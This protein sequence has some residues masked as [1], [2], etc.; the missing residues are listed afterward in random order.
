MP[1]PTGTQ[2]AVGDDGSFL[3]LNPDES[4]TKNV[5][6]EEAVPWLIQD[7]L[8][9]TPT[10]VLGLGQSLSSAKWKAPTISVE[11]M[12][13]TEAVAYLKIVGPPGSGDPAKLQ[14][15]HR[16]L[17][18]NPTVINVGTKVF[19]R[20]E[21]AKIWG[22][23]AVEAAEKNSL[24]NA[25]N[26]TPSNVIQNSATQGVG[27]LPAGNTLPTDGGANALPPNAKG[28][29]ASEDTHGQGTA[30]SPQQDQKTGGDPL[31]LA[32]G[33]LFLQ[34]TDFAGRGRGIHFAFTR[35]YLHQT[36]YRGPLGY[37][38]DHCYNLWLREAQELQPDGSVA[39]VVYRSNGELRE[40]RFLHVHGGGA[41]DPL[42]AIADAVFH[43]PPGYFDELSKVAG[44]YRLRMVNGTVITYNAELRVDS[45]ADLSGNRLSFTY[46]N[47]LLTR[48]TDAVGKIFDF[49]NDVCGRV[50]QVID[51]TG[52]RRV[53]YAYDDI[54]NLL[55]V[56]IF[57]D[58]QTAT[59]T[60]YVY[61]GVDAA[62]G[63]EHNLVEVIGADGFAS[64]FVQYGTQPDPWTYN[65]VI[66]QRSQDGAYLYDYGPAEFDIDP[67]LDDGINLP[68]RVTTVT[69]PNG[70]VIEHAFNKQG[71]VVRRR[72]DADLFVA[73]GGA[74]VALYNYNKEG[75]LVREQ[76]PDGATVSYLYAGDVYEELNGEGSALE[77]D[78]GERLG[79]GNL[80]RRAETAR[81]GSGETRQIVTRW[82]YRPG[83]SRVETQRGPYY[84]DPLGNEIP[85]QTTP[86]I[87]YA[88]D[89]KARLLQ[90]HYGAVQTANGT[91]QNLP[92][93]EFSYDAHGS[94]SELR[95]GTLVTRYRYFSDL[96]R[97]GFI[98]QRIEDAGGIARTT[99]FDIDDLG[100][101]VG[102]RDAYGAEARWKY[103]G[104]D[105]VT[106]AT[107]PSIGGTSPV[108]QVKYDRARRI[109]QL[110]EIVVLPDGSLHPDGPLIT[111]YRYD[112]NG[113]QI[114]QSMGPASNPNARRYQTIYTPWGQPRRKIDAAG[115]VT[116]FQYN[117]RNLLRREREAAGTGAQRDRH[118]H[119]NRSGEVTRVFD[120]LGHL[121][122]FERDGFGRVSAVIDRDGNRSESDYDAQGRATR[123]R[124]VG[125]NLG[126]TPSKLW[127]EAKLQFDAVGRLIRRTDVL[128]Q[129]EDP[130]VVPR[131]LVTMYFY[132]GFSR[133]SELHDPGGMVLRFSY[134]GLGRVT[135]T[136]DGDGNALRTEYDD[137]TRT[138]SVVSE[139]RAFGAA[140]ARSQFFRMS[141][142]FDELGLPAEETDSLGNTVQ[143]A[144]DSRGRRTAVTLPDARV[145]S[146]RYDIFG[147]LLEQTIG[148]GATVLTT[149]HE[150][151]AAGRRIA[152]VSPR[153]DRTELTYDARG[154]ITA[155]AT[156]LGIRRY[157]YDA[158]SRLIVEELA[159]GLR[160]YRT[161]SHEG[162]Q[163]TTAVDQSGYSPP[164]TLPTYAPVA[165][166]PMEYA[167]SPAGRLLRMEE[168]GSS[169]RF[170]YDSLH[171]VVR[172]F[173][174][175]TEFGY[176]WDDSG[177][178]SRLTFGDGRQVVYA[179][180]PGGYLT[181]IE[182]AQKGTGYPGDASLPAART[183]ATIKRVGPRVDHL[184]L[185]GLFEVDFDYDAGRRLVGMDYTFDGTILQQL[186]ILQG[187][188]GQRVLD[189]CSERLRTFSYDSAGRLEQVTDRP[190]VAVNVQALA[191]A[192]SA[193]GLSSGTTQMG[194]DTLAAAAQSLAGSAQRVFDYTFDASG[195]RETAKT[196][197][198]SGSVITNYVPM[199]GD[200]YANIDGTTLIYDADGNLLGDD[201]RAFRYDALG[202]LR[203]VAEG[204]ATTMLAYDP[205]GRLSTL[206][207]NGTQSHF[208]WAG[209]ALAEIAE[210]AG[211][212]A[213][214]Q[215]VPGDH[216]SSPVH[217]AANNTEYA[218]LLDDLNSVI[219]WVEAGGTQVGARTF[220]PF[221]RL[222]TQAGASPAPIA[223]A[224]Y[225]GGPAEVSWSFARAYDAR[226]GR[227][228]QCDPLGFVDGPNL[229]AFARNAPG[230][231]VDL[232]GYKS[233]DLDAGTVVWEA[234][235]TVATG[236]AVVAGGAA[237]VGAGIAS[238]PFVATVGVLVMV[239]VGMNSFFNRSEEAFK[240]GQ[241][242][243]AGAAGLAAL[244]DTIGITNIVEGATGKDAV[245]DRTLGSQ[246]RS[247]R[248][249]TGI[250]SVGT[251]M[252]GPKAGNFGKGIGASLN[253]G[254][255]AMGAVEGSAFRIAIQEGKPVVQLPEL[256]V[257]MTA[258]PPRQWANLDYTLPAPP[259]GEAIPDLPAPF[260]GGPTSA[261]TPGGPVI[262]SG[263]HGPYPNAAVDV[264]NYSQNNGLPLRPHG[265]FDKMPNLG[266]EGAYASTHAELKALFVDPNAN[267]AIVNRN[268]CPGCQMSLRWLAAHRG[269]PITVLGPSGFYHFLPDGTV[270]AP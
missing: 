201:S 74:L 268:P 216:P 158:E 26:P 237:L 214:T 101:M 97:S 178:R 243:P 217:V 92:A 1:P 173:T 9:G 215:L 43:G 36:T 56:D 169:V 155:A 240:A 263:L 116:E 109:Q 4:I 179:Y 266:A 241:T 261:A 3:R 52:G 44:V 154:R 191:P 141:T 166:G 16:V 20:D 25:D 229:Y 202:R 131:E 54:G 85:G 235:K 197:G 58:A 247:Q 123:R 107:A 70:H 150:Y 248:L 163:L 112:Q 126:P 262:D 225:L 91:V 37:S 38:W 148:D 133:L 46:Q 244:G 125:P 78:S 175:A 267:F 39:N 223:F 90:I 62:A 193:S 8:R 200:R 61:L 183:L 265:F 245:T 124:L 27:P 222:L 143:Q 82:T 259:P 221:G 83:G 129:P 145:M 86:S 185:P 11:G 59:S 172:E 108:T 186:R 47:G 45:I 60:D 65:R 224:G 111:R 257:D 50:A 69:Y 140:P 195:N 204:G 98:A 205:I 35:T 22:A 180:T 203:E 96:L 137:A 246:E 40:D 230:T 194:V 254:A 181:K 264:W 100:R 48:V 34:V 28:G 32:T 12:A 102:M 72:E 177:R 117:G 73:G 161:Y 227:F 18:D 250:G 176:D 71:N 188:G 115:G 260:K 87:T 190:P 88:Y 24:E 218:P 212:P 171:R 7:Y 2:Y 42:G 104:F 249:G 198:L 128:F 41:V 89:G 149:L 76:R 199:A 79:F 144:Y 207:D 6:A 232:F 228:L 31:I 118:F 220:D 152:L 252:L 80:L 211:G 29:S 159:S 105:L 146:H 138:V 164:A 134:D 234:T 147:Q 258:K 233:N 167:Y 19:G 157:R 256:N 99:S 127:A 165:I 63:L 121:T 94:L 210:T 156:P 93:A 162:L 219:G 10:L 68:L 75:L 15:L 21:A 151:D 114:E 142:K 184:E 120:G 160:I 106:E 168:A 174:S 14:K 255:G 49:V 103:N 239:G 135:E 189:V 213:V 51:R 196:T 236:A 136:I 153:G 57:A 192:S 77:A 23:Q 253:P 64:L 209:V 226:H 110:T 84:A 139:E 13:E 33:Q 122:V 95:V 119:Y 55:E 182:Q 251:L 67:V 53:A 130:T 206:Q 269:K 242:D 113:R 238:A 231:R 81:S 132:D 5:A 270:H 17:G 170:A 66:E 187:G 30:S 208:R